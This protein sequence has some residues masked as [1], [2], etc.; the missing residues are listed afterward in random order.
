MGIIMIKDH[1]EHRSKMIRVE[2]CFQSLA[3]IP[4]NKV[5]MP[6][7]MNSKSIVNLK[8]PNLTV[9]FSKKVNGFIRKL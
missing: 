7:F 9:S 2:L 6:P 3:P 1:G 4:V 5:K 8:I